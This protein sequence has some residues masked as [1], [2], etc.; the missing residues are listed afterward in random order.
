MSEL[1]AGRRGLL[2][3]RLGSRGQALVTTTDLGHVPGAEA[4]EVTRLRVV[5]GT[6]SGDE[7][8]SLAA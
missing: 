7:A 3:A 2:A 8:P 4:P 1:D 6:V 5:D